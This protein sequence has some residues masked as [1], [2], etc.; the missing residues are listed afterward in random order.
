MSQKIPFASWMW[1]CMTVCHSVIDDVVPISNLNSWMVEEVLHSFDTHIDARCFFWSICNPILWGRII[2]P[3]VVCHQPFKIHRQQ[4]P[5]VPRNSLTCL[6]FFGV[7]IF[8][9]VSLHAS[10]I[11]LWP[12][13]K[14]YPKYITW[15][16]QIWDFLAEALYL[17]YP[18]ACSKFS[19]P[20]CRPPHPQLPPTDHQHI[21][22][23]LPQRSRLCTHT[24]LYAWLH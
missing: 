3:S 21:V 12:S 8:N 19:V 16:L 10:E 15:D 20:L 7:G 1:E 23:G 2:F 9:T 17:E 11:H 13:S 6:T 24:N 18:Y 4:S 22:G 5:V 14:M